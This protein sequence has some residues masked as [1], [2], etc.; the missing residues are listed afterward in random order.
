[1]QLTY[2]KLSTGA[3]EVTGRYQ[4]ATVTYGHRYRDVASWVTLAALWRIARGTV[5]RAMTGV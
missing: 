2:R 1:M 3:W 5:D 4:G